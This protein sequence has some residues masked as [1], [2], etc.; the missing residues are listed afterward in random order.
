ME[1]NT[2]DEIEKE[3]DAPE[4]LVDAVEIRNLIRN[5]N[6]GKVSN[7]LSKAQAEFG[8]F[9]ADKDAYSF[10]YLTLAGILEKALPILGRCK[11][12]LAQSV[13]VEVKSDQPWVSVHTVLSCEDE[14]FENELS[15]PMM[16][17][18]KGMTEDLM[19]L[20]STA[21][22]LRRYSVQLMLG[23]TG[24]DKEVEEVVEEGKDRPNPNALK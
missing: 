22:Y 4:I 14:S 24:G 20:G 9:H 11:L 6:T 12:S 18:R 15:F 19:L 16:E 13:N 7:A 8:K 21:S 1:N 10:S 23:I 5:K 3:M 17:A 2:I